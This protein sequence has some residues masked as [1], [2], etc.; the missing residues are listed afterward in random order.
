MFLT[1]IAAILLLVGF[2]LVLRSYHSA[3]AG[4]ITDEQRK[5]WRV[6]LMALGACAF[7]II[8]I[9][10]GIALTLIVGVMLMGSHVIGSRTT[11]ETIGD[12]IVFAV[13]LLFACAGA[14]LGFAAEGWIARRS[15][16]TPAPDAR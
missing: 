12:S 2:P 11:G 4:G 16:P 14:G 6:A 13:A 5:P 10:A 7:G 9:I 1:L 3:L 8:G 15:V